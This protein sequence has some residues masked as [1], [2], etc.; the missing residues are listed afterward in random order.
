[1][2]QLYSYLTNDPAYKL[3]QLPPDLLEA[4]KSNEPLMFKEGQPTIVLCSNDKTWS[5]RQNDHS[6]SVLHLKQFN[7]NSDSSN[8]NDYSI[9][10]YANTTFELEPALIENP[11]LDISRVPILN[12]F[13]S[14]DTIKT[15]TFDNLIKN[16]PCSYNEGKSLFNKMNG[17]IIDNYCFILS[18]N[19]T[20]R[21]LNLFI[22]SLLA[23]NIDLD[24]FKE[25]DAIEAIYKDDSCEDNK[26]VFN[27]IIHKFC[28]KIVEVDKNIFWKLDK[29]NISK[30]YGI[31]A[32][33]KF[34]MKEINILEFL[35]SWRSEFPPFFEISIEIDILKGNYCRPKESSIL[36]IDR[37]VLPIDPKTR[38]N[39]LFEFQN[40]WNEDDIL[41]FIDD[42]LSH[43]K[44]IKIKNFLMKYTRRKQVGKKILISKR[45]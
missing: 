27:T 35:Q 30:W 16:S 4:V 24:K 21:L 17:C 2:P 26:Q 7:S 45:G 18:N 11:T 10:S 39:Y 22:M 29:D 40:I 34:A 38:F 15:I 9:I 44:N 19:Y 3:I 14:Y 36:F 31:I 37:S 32:L 5:I 20:T 28:N 12:S 43:N 1:M 42:I 25:I 41:P 6:N 23:Y 13:D 33:K 8:E